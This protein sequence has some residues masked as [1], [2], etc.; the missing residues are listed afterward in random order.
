MIN[1]NRVMIAGK[2][3]RKPSLKQHDNGRISAEFC[4]DLS[5]TWKDANGKKTSDSNFVPVITWGELAKNCA[6]FLKK[7]KEVMVEGYL[8][9]EEN[10][11]VNANNITFME[12]TNGG[13]E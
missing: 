11:V 7:G 9:L 2:I 12:K 5:R 13:K 10:L 4:I 1:L 3:D 6:K 8:Q